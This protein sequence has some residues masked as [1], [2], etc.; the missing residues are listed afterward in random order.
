MN[1]KW[2]KTLTAG[3]AVLMI[4]MTGIIGLAD[5]TTTENGSEKGSTVAKHPK[6]VRISVTKDGFTPS[7]I[8]VEKGYELTL[9]FNRTDSK[10]CSKDV[11]FSSLNIR[12]KLELKK[13]VTIVITPQEAGE[14]VFACSSGKAKGTITVH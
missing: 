10:G 12:R 9:I 8:R 1:I 4:G 7:Q 5:D 14:I 13:D 6:T 3:V 11:V 2:T